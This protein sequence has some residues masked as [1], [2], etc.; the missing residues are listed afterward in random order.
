MHG[1]LAAP[2]PITGSTS[3]A[4]TAPRRLASHDILRGGGEPP[5]E[6]SSVALSTQ[7]CVKNI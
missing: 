1:R 7:S 5:S 4:D 6:R 3:E 2:V